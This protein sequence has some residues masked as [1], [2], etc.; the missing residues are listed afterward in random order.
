MTFNSSIGPYSMKDL[1]RCARGF[2][3]SR[4][5]LTAVELGVFQSIGRDHLTVAQLSSKTETDPDGLEVLLNALTAAS[6]IRKKD[7]M[8]SNH[9]QMAELFIQDSPHY[10]GDVFHHCA[11]HWAS[12]CDLTKIVKTG[13]HGS[14]S[15]TQQ[16]QINL[17]NTMKYQAKMTAPHIISQVDFSNAKR[18]IDLGG[19]PGGYGIEFA[20][21]NPDLTVVIFERNE[22]ALKIA[23]RDAKCRNVLPRVIIQNGDFFVDDIGQGYDLVFLSSV[24]CLFSPEKA[25]LLLDR[26]ARALNVGGQLV[27]VDIMPNGD[28]TGPLNAAMFAVTILV[29]TTGGRCHSIQE[30]QTLLR[31]VG[32]KDMRHFPAGDLCAVVGKK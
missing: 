30:V 9:P 18:M 1:V 21:F 11:A 4:V 10:Q 25:R 29:N 28:R 27:V 17:A 22:E 2:M 5:F 23:V 7:S 19:G 8:Y 32:L 14:R 13:E 20:C 15:W 16:E 6:L 3:T 24:L 12:W 31:S 26:A